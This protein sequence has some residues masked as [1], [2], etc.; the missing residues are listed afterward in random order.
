[1]PAG[2]YLVF[3]TVASLGIGKTLGEKLRLP[4]ILLTMHMSWGAGFLTSP[5]TLV[6]EGE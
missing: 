5:R 2:V 6:P 4:A 1:L 3:L